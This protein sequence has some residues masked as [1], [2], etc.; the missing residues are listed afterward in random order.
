MIR[1]ASPNTQAL[2]IWLVWQQDIWGSSC[3]LALAHSEH[4]EEKVPLAFG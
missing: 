4:E 3:R 1:A 2:E